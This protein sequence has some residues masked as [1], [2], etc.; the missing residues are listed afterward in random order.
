MGVKTSRISS[1][2]N[3]V[4]IAIT[5]LILLCGLILYVA[6][7]LGWSIDGVRSGSMAPEIERGTLVIAQPVKPESIAVN[8]VIIFRPV[9]M[10]ENLL[11]HRVIGIQNISPLWLTTKGDANP[12]PDPTPVPARNIKGKVIF[13]IPILGFV[14]MFFKTP[15]GFIVSVVLPGAALALLCLQSLS[16]ELKRNKVMPPRQQQ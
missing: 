5:A 8:D 16:T 10:G 11:V 2:L 14:A 13:R 15:V 12:L 9:N 7:H 4:G 3:I 1:T 6:P